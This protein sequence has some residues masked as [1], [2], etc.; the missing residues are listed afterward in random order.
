M[1]LMENTIRKI[2]DVFINDLKYPVYNIEGKEHQ[3]LNGGPATWWLYY[4]RWIDVD[5]IAPPIDS[6]K[7]IPYEDIAIPRSVWDIRYKQ[8][9]SSKIKWGDHSFSQTGYVEIYR[10]GELFYGFPARKIDYALSKAQSIITELSEH[11]FNFYDPKSE[12]GRKIWF[13]GLPAIVRVRKS[14]PFF[15]DIYPD[16]T[17]MT[18]GEWWQKYRQKEMETKQTKEDIEWHKDHLDELES[19]GFINWGDAYSDQH[20]GWFRK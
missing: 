6:E 12:D 17:T 16:L 18:K 10:N 8:K 14:E 13:K 1:S 9:I 4:D 19:M 2:F 11:C 7:W 20:I 5:G 15:I 3:S